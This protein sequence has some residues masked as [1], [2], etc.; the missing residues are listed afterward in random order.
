MNLV[1]TQPLVRHVL[2][3]GGCNVLA[4]LIQGFIQATVSADE[5][6]GRRGNSELPSKFGSLKSEF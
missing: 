5:P 1:G 4:R 2:T 3:E 6:M